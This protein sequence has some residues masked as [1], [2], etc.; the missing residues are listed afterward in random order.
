MIAAIIYSWNIKHCL[1][2]QKDN[3]K[4]KI[5]RQ[6]SNSIKDHANTLV[7]T[8][9]NENVSSENIGNSKNNNNH[10]NR[11][12]HENHNNNNNDNNNQNNKNE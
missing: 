10:N 1:N 9:E 12:N 11:N 6:M 5:E 4:S 2:S 7:P 3:E 8:F